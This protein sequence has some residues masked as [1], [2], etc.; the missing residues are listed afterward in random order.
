MGLAE[1]A[2]NHKKEQNMEQSQAAPSLGIFQD[3]LWATYIGKSSNNIYVCSSSDGLNW[4]GH[5]DVGWT[6]RNS[7]S[8]IGFQ[9][10]LWI[11]F[12]GENN[13]SVYICSS[14]DGITWSG[15]APVG[16]TSIAAPAL[17]VFQNKLWIAFIADNGSNDI[18][19]C[20]SADGKK[21]STATQI[22]NQ[23]SKASPSLAVSNGKLW[24]AFIGN[25]SN[26]TYTYYTDDG[27]KWLPITLNQLSFAPP[28][29]VDFGGTLWVAFTGNNTNDLWVCSLDRNTKKWSNNHSIP[30]QT[31]QA[32][33]SLTQFKGKLIIGFVS[34]NASDT[35]F[36]CSSVDGQNWSQASRI[37]SY[38]T[39]KTFSPT[40]YPATVPYG[41]GVNQAQ[42]CTQLIMK[43]DGSYTFMG[44]YTNNGTMPVL[45]APAQNYSVAIVLLA[46]NQP[47]SFEHSAT[48][49]N[50]NNDS[51][52]ISGKS[53]YIAANWPAIAN[54]RCTFKSENS[55]TGIISAV[56]DALSE[57]L[58][59]AETAAEVFGAVCAVI[60]IVAP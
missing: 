28:S 46:N 25:T 43:S 40:A 55:T 44:I 52:S 14:S 37:D 12:R 21:W 38:P 9:G 19:I 16:Q 5:T 30:G 29:L 41:S 45:T 35:L 39:T 11:T 57:L 3:K 2:K 48:C 15:N 1:E 47:F 53:A 58:S 24:V 32:A 10:K 36:V 49:Q 56:G 50:A 33:P 42:F 6:S 7:P 27:I 18:L 22:P 20:S 13:N 8:I 59:I 54:A 23:R 31:S 60:A 4:S 51:W 26:G 34:Q 17:A